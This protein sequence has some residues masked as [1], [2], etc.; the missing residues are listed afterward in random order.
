MVVFTMAALIFAILG[1]FAVN[2]TARDIVKKDIAF[3]DSIG[4]LRESIVAQERAAG[5]FSIIKESEF[6][7]L[8]QRRQAEFKDY[9]NDLDKEGH[10]NDEVVLDRLYAAFLQKSVPVFTG[11]TTDIAPLHDASSGIQSFL[12]QL[13]TRER[14]MLGGKLVSADQ[15]ESST[16]RWTVILAL[17]GFILAM[18]VAAYSIFTISAAITKLKKA[19]RRIAKGDFDY[20]PEIPA[21]DEIGEL[22]QE[23]SRM[24][25]RLKVME[26]ISLDASPLTRLPGNIAIE[27]V[28]NQRLA[29]GNPFAVYY[30]DL[31]NLKAY[32]DHYGYIK[33]SEVIKKSAE[34]IDQAVRKAADAEAFVGHV[35]GDDFV[36]VADSEVADLLCK[37]IITD[38][39]AEIVNHYTAEDLARGAIEGPDRYGVQRVFPIMTI[40]IAVIISSDGEYS[41]A[42]EIAKA[43]AEIKDHVKGL[44]GSNYMVNRRRPRR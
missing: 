8:F 32:N 35:G 38:F 17:C 21:G 15:K 16:V 26:Q 30:A 28:L 13:Y 29:E 23:F 42:T 25:A 33:A 34:V 44:P 31:D 7:A 20:D 41:S 14:R 19:T 40:S 27:R 4:N 3:I 43:A 24:A 36:I 39:E 37:Q 10:H 9:L 2:R 12:D 1:L 5:Q 11:K 18:A 6:A 22:A